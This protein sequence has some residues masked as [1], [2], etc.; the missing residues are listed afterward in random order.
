MVQ[1]TDWLLDA[2]AELLVR[3]HLSGFLLGDCVSGKLLDLQASGLFPAD[4]DRPEITERIR[5]RL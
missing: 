5:R 1:P 2:L 3:L 4:A